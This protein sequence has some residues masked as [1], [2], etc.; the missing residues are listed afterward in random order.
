MQDL[1]IMVV[2]V[3]QVEGELMSSD[4]GWMVETKK[5]YLNHVVEVRSRNRKEEGS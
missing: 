5:R 3:A 2:V 4:W 1:Q